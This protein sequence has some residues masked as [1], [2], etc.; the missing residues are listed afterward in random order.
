MMEDEVQEVQEFRTR[1]DGWGA[2]FLSLASNQ[3]PH[4]L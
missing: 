2:L 4:V 1:V 3:D